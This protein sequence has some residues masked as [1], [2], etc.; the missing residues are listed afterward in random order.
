M[1]R[2]DTTPSEPG[3]SEYRRELNSYLLGLLLALVLTG[4]PFSLVYE[5]V[6][7]RFWTLIAIGALALIQ[8]MVH[9]RFF[10][11]IDP[12]RQ[13]L[14]DLHLMLFSALILLM[15]AGG[16]IWILSNLAV[17]MQ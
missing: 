16:T 17:R 14:D 2:A 11:H 13:K 7:P 9:F 6:L 8:V 4:I 3:K 10:L 5:P 15:M 12:P 1:G